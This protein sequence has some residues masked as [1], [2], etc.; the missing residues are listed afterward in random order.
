M[1]KRDALT[2]E[3]AELEEEESRLASERESA[4]HPDIVEDEADL[5]ED[6]I[7]QE[8]VDAL[9]EAVSYKKAKVIN[10]LNHLG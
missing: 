1:S 6:L 8:T 7:E 2:R 10:E 4:E 5:A 3:L 9:L